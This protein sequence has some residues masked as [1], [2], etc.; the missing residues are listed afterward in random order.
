MVLVENIPSVKRQPYF[1]EKEAARTSRGR[2]WMRSAKRGSP[3]GYEIDTSKDPA[4]S[5]MVGVAM[6][7]VT[8]ISGV[9]E[10][11][12]TSVNPNFAAVVLRCSKKPA[13]KRAIPWQSAS[14]LVPRHQPQR[15]CGDGDAQP[16]ANHHPERLRLAMGA[17]ISPT[18]CGSTWSGC[19]TSAG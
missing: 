18:C 5:G 6:S 1:R 3:C 8:S 2:A 16:Q 11:K 12:Q 9:L 7:P 4:E 15:L 17:R 13:S 14:R 19:S 10:A